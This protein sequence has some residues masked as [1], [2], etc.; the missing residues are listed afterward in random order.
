MSSQGNVARA[1]RVLQQIV[2][3]TRTLVQLFYS[4]VCCSDCNDRNQLARALERD[5]ETDLV[6]AYEHW[7]VQIQ[8]L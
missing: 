2:T 7:H 4:F 3:Q 1:E 5:L 8:S 6:K